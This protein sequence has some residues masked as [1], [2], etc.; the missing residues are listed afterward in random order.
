MFLA[1]W[2]GQRTDVLRQTHHRETR[3]RCRRGRCWCGCRWLR[4]AWM[5]QLQQALAWPQLA[6][7]LLVLVRLEAQPPPALVLV[8][9][10]R[11][12]CRR[13]RWLG[14]DRFYCGGWRGRLRRR[15]RPPVCESATARRRGSSRRDATSA[16]ARAARLRSPRWPGRGCSNLPDIPPHTLH[17][18]RSR[19][20]RCT[21]TAQCKR[22]L[23]RSRDST[24]RRSSHGAP[25]A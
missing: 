3:R 18:R 23:V 7:P 15:W 14:R 12:L 1:N 17:G 10:R 16:R 9:W 5:L 24:R 4:R 13:W 2:S 25:P 19:R 6:R 20:I 22:C 11:S 8:R 21:S